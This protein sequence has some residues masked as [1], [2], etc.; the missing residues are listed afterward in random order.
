[1]A[2]SQQVLVDQLNKHCQCVG[3]DVVALRTWLDN[4]L[5][6]RGV[7]EPIVETHPHLFS[8]LPV[9][10]ANEQ[11]EAMR[12]IITAIESVVTLPAYV[13]TALKRAPK[14]AQ[15]VPPARGVFMGYEFHLSDDGPKLIEIN[16]NAGGAMLN[17][18]MTRAQQACCPEVAEYLRTQPDAEALEETIVAMF[19]E[20]WRR[21]RGD[22]KLSS[23]AIVDEAPD[24][25]YLYPELLLFQRLFQSRGVHTVI[26]SPAELDYRQNALW[27]GEQQIDLVY[28]R[29]TD[30]YLE[31]PA[32]AMLARSYIDNAVVLTPHPHAHAVYANKHNLMLLSDAQ[33][34]SSLNVPDDI[35]AVLLDGVPRTLPV[36]ANDSERWWTDRKQWF[37]KPAS[38]FGSRGTYRGDKL[39]RKA[40]AEIVQRDYVAQLL[41]LPPQ[42][43]MSNAAESAL[44]FDVRNYAY[45][46]ETQ[47]VGARLYQGQ[48]TNFRTDGGG[49]SPVY[50]IAG[51]GRM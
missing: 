26:A 17:V 30:F 23:I 44:K 50:S 34:L 49:F 21:S 22:R 36:S 37:F 41:V 33:V 48:T 19:M 35:I 2:I 29:L 10:V 45:A 11:M 14:I 1:M 31:A 51:S 43:W 27:I 5:K 16:T 46:G 25:Q 15:W 7:M 47:I 18:A 9:F 4:D 20:E 24:T 6:Q 42:R 3:T 40:F 38:G 13:G 32:Q 39:T 28:N 12:R 8:E